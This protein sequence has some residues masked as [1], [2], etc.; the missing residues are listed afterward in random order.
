MKNEPVKKVETFDDSEGRVLSDVLSNALIPAY[1]MY[2]DNCRVIS[3][4]CIILSDSKKEGSVQHVLCAEYLLRFHHYFLIAE[5]NPKSN[6]VK[7]L[8]MNMATY[9]IDELLAICDK[10]IEHLSDSLSYT[11]EFEDVYFRAETFFRA[12]RK[13]CIRVAAPQTN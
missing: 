11:D 3:D 2:E 4:T 8:T 5:R 10:C 6:I 13:V 12:L 7:V 9:V 1:E